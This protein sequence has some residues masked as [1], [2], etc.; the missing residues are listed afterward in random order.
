MKFGRVQFNQKPCLQAKKLFHN[1]I[2]QLLNILVI[3]DLFCFATQ[4]TWNIGDQLNPNFTTYIFCYLSSLSF[5]FIEFCIL[6]LRSSVEWWEYNWSWSTVDGIFEN[7]IS[8]LDALK[9]STLETSI[10]YLEW[11]YSSPL[12][13]SQ[14]S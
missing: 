8:G 9:H 13:S 4:W 14:T 6:Y 3:G 5:A 10:W 12:H 11:E 1:I 7:V 2:C